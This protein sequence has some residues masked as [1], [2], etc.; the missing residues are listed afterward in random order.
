MNDTVFKSQA[1]H[2]A[3]VSILTQKLGI[4]KLLE[5][6]LLVCDLL[7]KGQ[8]KWKVGGVFGDFKENTIDFISR[9]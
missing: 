3:H 7:I 8:L 2:I 5:W 6:W 9:Y 4:N 1:S